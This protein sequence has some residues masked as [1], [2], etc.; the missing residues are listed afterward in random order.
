MKQELL[1]VKELAVELRM[2]QKS[3]QQAYRKGEIGW[4]VWRSLISPK[5]N[6][7]WNAT[8]GPV[9]GVSI[10]FVVL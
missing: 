3:I 5:F 7:R 2:R 10:P 6:G 4:V 8:A 1:A 9:C